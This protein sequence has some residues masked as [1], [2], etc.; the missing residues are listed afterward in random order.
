MVSRLSIILIVIF[1]LITF[2][3]FKTLKRVIKAIINFRKLGK[4]E[5]MKRLNYGF[6]TITPAQR[7]KGE[8][9]GV[10][11][12]LIGILIGLIVT[13]IVRLE[14]IWWWAE[15]ILAGSFIVIAFSLLSTWQKYIGYKKQDDLIKK[16]NEEKE[17]ELE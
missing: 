7:T 17:N 16:L 10:I 9:N 6:E 15:I 4:E 13:P 14:G 12:S 8:L 1:I 3:A 2:F 11:I 5:F